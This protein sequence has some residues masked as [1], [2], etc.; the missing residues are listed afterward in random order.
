MALGGLWHGANSTFLIWGLMHGVA[1]V[2]ERMIGIT[3]RVHRHVL[4]MPLAWLVTFHFICLT[5]VFF[6]ASSF[7]SAISYLYA[8]VSDHS[9]STTISPLVATILVL[10]AATQIVPAYLWNFF[11]RDSNRGSRRTA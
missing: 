5:W 9:I 3:G 4:P 2:V 11:R 6:R 8:L 10:G 1:L 7:E